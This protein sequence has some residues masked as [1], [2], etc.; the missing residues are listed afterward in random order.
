MTDCAAAGIA[1]GL[2]KTWLLLTSQ[3]ATVVF[4]LISEQPFFPPWAWRRWL[5]H[6]IKFPV[7]DTKVSQQANTSACWVCLDTSSHLV[8]V[9]NPSIWKATALQPS[10]RVDNYVAYHRP[11]GSP[12]IVV[13]ATR[14]VR[15]R[16]G[17]I[18]SCWACMRTNTFDLVCSR[19]ESR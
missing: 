7:C 15:P 10:G 9:T 17:G 6:A 14:E 11:V 8:H 13:E 19:I 5:S 3:S 16:T 2:A 1:S 18:R 12:L 4:A